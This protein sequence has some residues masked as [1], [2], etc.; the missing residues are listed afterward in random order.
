MAL[1]FTAWIRAQSKSR[2][3]ETLVSGTR[4][5]QSRSGGG[6][7]HPHPQAAMVFAPL[8]SGRVAQ[9]GAEQGASRP[10]PFPPFAALWLPSE[11]G[12]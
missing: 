2:D 4:D 5:A 12:G 10:P 11:R 7:M 1:S 3:M 6:L 8:V 9:A